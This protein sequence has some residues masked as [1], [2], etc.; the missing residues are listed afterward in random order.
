MTT[1][2]STTITACPNC[3]EKIRCIGLPGQKIIATCPKCNSKG[4]V[5]LPNIVETETTKMVPESSLVKDELD[6]LVGEETRRDLALSTSDEKILEELEKGQESDIILEQY[7][8]DGEKKKKGIG[9]KDRARRFI[10]PFWQK[11]AHG[12]PV[13]FEDTGEKIGTVSNI[14]TNDQGDAMGYEVQDSKSDTALYFPKEN[15]REGKLGLIFTPLW[16]SQA[17]EI[18]GEL[19][20]REKNLPE[21]EDILLAGAVSKEKIYSI[22]TRSR[23]KLRKLIDEGVLL[24]AVM[25]DR[26][27][28][29]ELEYIKIRRNMVQLSEKRLLKKVSRTEFARQILEARKKSRVL[30][31]NI[32]RCKMLVVR[33]DRLPFITKYREV[34]RA[35]PSFKDIVEDMPINVIVT[36]IEGQVVETNKTISASLGYTQSEIQEKRIV[37]FVSDDDKKKI[38]VVSRQILEDEMPRDIKFRIISK[39]GKAMEMHARG[40]VIKGNFSSES[41]VLWAFQKTTFEEEIVVKKKVVREISHDFINPL[42]ISKGYIHLMMEGEFGELTEEQ[43]EQ[44]ENLK[45]NVSRIDDLLQ[46]TLNNVVKEKTGGRLHK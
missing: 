32:K 5:R 25:A 36:D 16:Y 31:I 38:L 19:E 45:S 39:D 26:L 35:M 22:L 6:E 21:L 34:I 44:L 33:L 42:C 37:D 14:I 40:T 11:S 17:N 41:R 24:R 3:G 20:F 1:M 28:D 46:N 43:T 8:L 9:T 4:Y 12:K 7:L 2:T 23:P 15:F 13:Y 18:I 27:E 10:W 30:E 29:L